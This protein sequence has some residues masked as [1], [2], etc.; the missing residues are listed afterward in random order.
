MVEEQYCNYGVVMRGQGRGRGV[1][2]RGY[3]QYGNQS[4]SCH[5]Y[6]HYHLI[7]N[8]SIGLS[9]ISAGAKK[10][11]GSATFTGPNDQDS[12][13][14]TSKFHREL[15]SPTLFLFE[16]LKMSELTRGPLVLYHLPKY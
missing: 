7:I 9:A 2:Y 1:P 13:R 4:V 3:N 10:G 6:N 11:E 12:I 5:G 15:M 16:L 8:S 14:Q